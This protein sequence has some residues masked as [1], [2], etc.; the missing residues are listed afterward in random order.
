MNSPHL[1]L[2]ETDSDLKSEK[3]PKI[4]RKSSGKLLIKSPTNLESKKNNENEKILS[5]RNY[6]MKSNEINI[7]TK[8][9]E[10]KINEKKSKE[11][12]LSPR[13]VR[14]E[15]KEDEK[16][17]ENQE[18]FS[19][20]KK[21]STINSEERPN[22]SKNPK[23][24]VPIS[25]LPSETDNDKKDEPK[26]SSSPSSGIGENDKRK[27]KRR[28]KTINLIATQIGKIPDY[29]SYS[30]LE[31]VRAWTALENRLDELQAVHTDWDIQ[32]PDPQKETLKQ[33]HHRYIQYLNDH[34]R[35]KFIAENSENYI[36]GMVI[37]WLLLEVICTMIFN[38]P[39][40]GYTMLQFSMIHR[41]EDILVDI[42]EEA[43][44]LKGKGKKKR[45]TFWDIIMGSLLVALG[46]VLFNFFLRGL[47]E[48]YAQRISGKLITMLIGNVADG[49]GSIFKMTGVADVIKTVK[50]LMSGDLSVL[51][52]LLG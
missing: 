36:V 16:E 5:P 17:S 39:A 42:G 31:K 29:D 27:T 13:N 6:K 19:N 8:L 40:G 38:L 24:E 46:F 22:S 25:S 21:R 12:P 37:F 9:N 43:W 49:E 15:L 47:G 20:T 2:S 18:L 50:G 11:R 48:E 28:K 35:E 14:M 4:V 32:N 34:K 10:D 1:I 26:S 23:M 3:G 44:E 7:I 41:Y 30:E 51:T 52:G 33:C 45:G